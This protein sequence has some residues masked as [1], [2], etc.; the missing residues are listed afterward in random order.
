[1]LLTNKQT[2][3]QTN[4]TENIISFCQDRPVARLFC[5]GGGGV[6]SVKFGDL[7]WLRVDYLA[8]ALNLAILSDPPDPTLATGLQEGN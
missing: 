5:G 1:M 3:K 7:L 6:K 4:A 2:D 8:I